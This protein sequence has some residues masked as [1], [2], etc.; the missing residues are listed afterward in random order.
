MEKTNLIELYDKLIASYPE[1]PRKGK[2]MP[3]TSLNG[4]MF[5][6]V[7]KEGDLGIRLSKENQTFYIEN[8]ESDF[9]IS[10]GAVMNGYI[11]V[12]DSIIM[13]EKLLKEIFA[14]SIEFVK[15]LKPKPTKK[16]K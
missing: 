1:I 5:S 6:F 3:Y 13:D 16:K 2:A 11:K 12:P 9:L 10:H 4:N 15:S 14:K 7:S 8:T